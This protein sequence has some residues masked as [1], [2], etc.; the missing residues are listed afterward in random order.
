MN[1]MKTTISSDFPFQS[2]YLHILDSTIHYIDIEGDK[3]SETVFLYVHG[4]PTSIYLWR[5]II[6]YSIPFGRSIALDLI[7]FGKSG[8]PNIKYSFQDHIKYVNEFINKLDLKNIV[9]VLHDWGGAIGFN[10]AM[11]NPSNIKGIVFMETFCKPMEWNDLNFFTRWVFK[12]FRNEKSGQ[13]WNGKY[14]VFL[15]FILPMSINR[16]LNDIEKQFY[17]EPFK[18]IESRAPIIKF[19]KELPFK[20]DNTSNEKIA[21]SYYEWLKVTSTPKLLLYTKPG[22]QVTSREVSIYESKFEN[23]TTAF[24]GKGKHFIQEDQPE[25]IGEA[26]EN[27]YLLKFKPYN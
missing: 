18:T 27:W 14:N 5:N 16:K 9:L 17:N 8:K 25:N 6:P 20:N 1:F 11:N 13:K 7:G 23:L 26:I 24:V 4:N 15:R 21:F 10:Y 3:K 19:P 12:K 2:H 22:V